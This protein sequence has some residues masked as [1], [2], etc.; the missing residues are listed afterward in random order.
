MLVENYHN[1]QCFSF[2]SIDSFCFQPEC[3][4][5]HIPYNES[6]VPFPI[7]LV[8]CGQCGKGKVPDILF[9][10]VEPPSCVSF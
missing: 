8:K 4:V 9:T 7:K 6:S 1:I 5:C 10:T 3:G 2:L